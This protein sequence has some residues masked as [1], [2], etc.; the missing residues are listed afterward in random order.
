MGPGIVYPEKPAVIPLSQDDIEIEKLSPGEIIHIFCKGDATD[1]VESIVKGLYLLH[2]A[3]NFGAEV[4]ET[5]KESELPPWLIMAF[6]EVKRLN[7]KALQDSE[8]NSFDFLA[9]FELK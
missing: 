2:Y 5:M 8:R 7:K 9:Q 4:D 3:E 1:L 6:T